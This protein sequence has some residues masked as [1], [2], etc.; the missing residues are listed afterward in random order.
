MID[1]TNGQRTLTDSIIF[2]PNMAHQPIMARELGGRLR[3]HLTKSDISMELEQ[4]YIIKFLTEEYVKTPEILARLRQHYGD[5]VF[6]QSTVYRWVRAAKLGRRDLSNI[7]SPG[8][9][10]DEGLRA[11]VARRH[12]KDPHLSARQIAKSLG[13]GHATVCRCLSDGLGL[14]C[15]HLRWV[16]H[17][18]TAD[19]KAK[20][21]SYAE[22]MLRILAT[23]QSTGFHYLFTGDESWIFYTYYDRTRWVYSWEDVEEAVRPSHYQKKT[24]VTIF[25]NGSGQFVIDI[26]PIGV[27]MD[28][29]Y[30]ADNIIDTLAGSCYPD[31]RQPGER[32]VMLHFDNAP[33]HCTAMI[34]ERMFLREFKKMDH[35]PYSPDLSP[36]DFFL[37]GY[38]KGE[39]TKRDY[40]TPE[41]L[42]FEIRS[43]TAGISPEL[44]RRVFESWIVRLQ[45]CINSGGEYVE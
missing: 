42:F 45:E 17:T 14:K 23:H 4:R 31:G 12:E 24:M 28:S 2:V 43:V 30:F 11:A 19:Q 8:R 35:P 36:C 26:L 16:P 41:D 40:A 1:G 3:W 39:L 9:T 7:P 29:T 44:C 6:S 32:K 10:P 33:I 22:V 38:L 15:L 21:A 20:R 13:V 18:L 27:K 34:T 25:F 5:R 37:F